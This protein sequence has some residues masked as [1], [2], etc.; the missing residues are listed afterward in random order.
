MGQLVQQGGGHALG[1][2]DLS[3]IGEAQIAG[4]DVGHALV[5]L[6]AER[7]QGLGAGGR[8]GDETQL[9]NDH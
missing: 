1:L 5:Q 2:K 3:P 4:D 8:K 7:E 9:I 6:R